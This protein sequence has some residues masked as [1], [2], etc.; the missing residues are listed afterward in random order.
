MGKY[1]LSHLHFANYNTKIRYASCP[2]RASSVQHRTYGTIFEVEP[3]VSNACVSSEVYILEV[4]IS[5]QLSCGL[6]M[7]ERRKKRN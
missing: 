2:R 3:A 6:C 4:K 7:I 1:V 5:G